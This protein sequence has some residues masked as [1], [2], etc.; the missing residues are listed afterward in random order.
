MNRESNNQIWSE[1]NNEMWSE[2][3][4][5]EKVK[6][7]FYNHSNTIMCHWN[8]INLTFNIKKHNHENTLTSNE[9]FVFSTRIHIDHANCQK[10]MWY[11]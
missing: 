1:T 8:L 6:S 11:A 4:F 5:T 7:F 3:W 10:N 9:S 2:T